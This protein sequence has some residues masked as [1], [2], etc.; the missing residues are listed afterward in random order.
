MKAYTDSED[1][2]R[3]YDTGR[4]KYSR[5]AVAALVQGC[6]MVET[7]PNAIV[8]L[9]AGHGRFTRLLADGVAHL[10]GDRRSRQLF[11]VEPAG[12]VARLASEAAAAPMAVT[13]VRA[14]AE[15]L[16]FRTGSIDAVVAAQS[17]HWFADAAVDEIHRVLAPGAPL[18]LYW[19]I[20]QAMTARGQFVQ[21]LAQL[22]DLITDAY[23]HSTPRQ[24]SGEWRVP[25]DASRL[26]APLRKTVIPSVWGG[27]L[28]TCTDGVMSVSG[29]A[30][31]SEADQAEIRR[32][33]RRL[34]RLAAAE[35]GQDSSATLRLPCEE[36]VWLTA[37][38]R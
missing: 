3:A 9:G 17:F 6:G 11:A 28:D 25:L 12:V 38:L 16:P 29:I 36:Q 8:E 30:S 5:K 37:A 22:E 21:A 20:R 34:L 24:Q 33:V 26:F 14:A 2:A 13:A 31:R 32:E 35:L 4:G 1:A 27:S 10:P 7:P 19:N 23:P 15:Q 18:A